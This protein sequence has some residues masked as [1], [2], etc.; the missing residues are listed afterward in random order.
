MLH[1]RRKSSANKPHWREATQKERIE[2]VGKCFDEEK[3]KLKQLKKDAK[4]RKPKVDEEEWKS[5]IEQDKKEWRQELH[6]E[7]DAWDKAITL[8]SYGGDDVVED[9]DDAGQSNKVHVEEDND[10]SQ[11]TKYDVCFDVRGHPGNRGFEKEVLNLLKKY[12]DTTWS[13]PVYKSLKKRLKGRRFFYGTMK[14]H[15]RELTQQ[16]RI[17]LFGTRY[18]A[19][20]KKM[21]ERQKREVGREAASQRM[22]G[23]PTSSATSSPSASLKVSYSPSASLKVTQ[24]TGET[25]VE[26]SQDGEGNRTPQQADK[27]RTGVDFITSARPGAPPLSDEGSGLVG[28]TPPTP[29]DK[30]VAIHSPRLKAKRSM[31]HPQEFDVCFGDDKHPGSI[32][33]R[34]IMQESVSQFDGEWSTSIYKGIKKQLLGRRYFLRTDPTLPWREATSD[35]RVELFKE[36]FEAERSRSL[37]KAS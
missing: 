7:N 37:Q 27:K 2:F 29:K 5:T 23:T 1:P 4:Q 8:H 9:R 32:S 19:E 15:W 26:R 14:G 28:E 13:P 25:P 6:D 31:K 33:F 17:D 22:A 30:K 11:P 16:E 21:K 3:S 12:P 24:T 35:E 36:S 20:K 34:E 10:E 18:E